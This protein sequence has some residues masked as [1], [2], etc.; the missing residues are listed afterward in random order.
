MLHFLSVMTQAGLFFKYLFLWILPNSAWM[1]ID[2]REQFIPVWTAWQGWLGIIAFL[3][4]GGLG[5]GLL[6]RGGGKGLLG[7]AMLYPWLLFLLEFSTIRVQE[8]FVL[9]RSYLWMPGMMLLFSLLL[10]RMPGR[11]TV[12]VLGVGVLLMIPLSWNR[13]GVFSDNYRLWND[14]ALLLPSEKVS[15]A[16]R[17][18]YNRGQ[19]ERREQRWD[20][21]TADFQRVVA[22]RPDLAPARY[23]L[24]M[25]FLNLGRYQEALVQFDAGISISP[26]SGQQYFGKGLTLFRMHETVP[27]QQQMSKACELGEQAACMMA[28]WMKGGK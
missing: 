15:G 11:R 17:I 5:L 20:D 19:A 28:G 16:D 12:R 14:A 26:E 27:A 8:P 13:L 18:F 6:L 2:M 7:F 10:A 9:Y 24:G 3:A 1:S 22:L 25:A 23:E 21:A 4:Y